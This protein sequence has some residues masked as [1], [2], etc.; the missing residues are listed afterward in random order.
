M[1]ISVYAKIGT[2]AISSEALMNIDI[3]AELLNIVAF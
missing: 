1:L 3:F 2:H